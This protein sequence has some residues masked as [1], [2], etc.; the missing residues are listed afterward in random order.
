MHAEIDAAAHGDVQ[1]A[2]HD[3][4]VVAAQD[5]VGTVDHR[6]LATERLENARELERD[7][8]A[9][10]DHQALGLF[11]EK[12]HLVRGDA[13]LDAGKVGHRRARPGGDEDDLGGKLPAAGE[14]DAVR[15]RDGRPLAKHLDLVVFERL[16]VKS[17][18]PIDIGV[19]EIAQSWPVE[20]L[21]L[22]GPAE[23]ARMLQLLGEH[24]TVDEHLLGHASANDAGPADAV[25]L[26]HGDLRAV[27]G[28][29]TTGAHAARSGADDEEVVVVVGHSVAPAARAIWP[30][31]QLSASAPPLSF[32]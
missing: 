13:M 21:A 32:R 19:D 30:C 23:V 2:L 22:D 9:A 16:A 28:G 18:E 3:L 20:A 29:Y 17:L 1:H 25:F 14:L 31:G 7:V 24:R 8:P 15:A 26:G 11:V 27:A 5:A 6:H 4:F 10:D 12:E